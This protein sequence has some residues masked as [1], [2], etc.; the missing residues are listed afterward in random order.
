[1][2]SL[3]KYSL[4][5]YLIYLNYWWFIVY[6]GILILL[7]M[8]YIVL[9]YVWIYMLIFLLVNVKCWDKFMNFIVF[10]KLL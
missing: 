8:I 2:Y 9:E 1:M 6:E 4:I 5:G 3:L 10:I 7:E